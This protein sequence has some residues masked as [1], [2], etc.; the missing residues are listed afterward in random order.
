MGILTKI[1]TEFDDDEQTIR[2]ICITRFG[3]TTRGSLNRVAGR[4]SN[5]VGVG[6]RSLVAAAYDEHGIDLVWN[7]GLRRMAPEEK[8]DAAQDIEYTTFSIDKASRFEDLLPPRIQDY[9][10][11]GNI[12][13]EE[14]VHI[15]EIPYKHSS[16]AGR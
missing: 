3:I 1:H 14:H 8:F 11:F 7:D 5:A 12:T 10:D 9:V 2:V 4:A 6:Q 13:G 15:W 16:M